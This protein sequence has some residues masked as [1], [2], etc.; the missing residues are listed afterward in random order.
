MKQKPEAIF[1]V[2]KAIVAAASIG[3]SACAH[4]TGAEPPAVRAQQNDAP[5]I[6]PWAGPVQNES[7]QEDPAS[8]R[9]PDSELAL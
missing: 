1:L 9:V 3:L 7:I 5:A 4:L 6:S 2:A 8:T